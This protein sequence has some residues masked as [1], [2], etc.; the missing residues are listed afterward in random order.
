MASLWLQRLQLESPGDAPRKPPSQGSETSRDAQAI[1]IELILLVAPGARGRAMLAFRILPR[2]PAHH[3]AVAVAV[4]PSR[5]VG[6]GRG[7][8]LIMPAI[9]DPFRNVAVHVVKAEPVGRK[10]SDRQRALTVHIRGSRP[11]SA[12]VIVRLARRQGISV[13]KPRCSAR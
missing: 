1:S 8:V 12:A 4:Q 11:V 9:F 2:S 6:W 3:A 10:A 5:A 13:R 7:R